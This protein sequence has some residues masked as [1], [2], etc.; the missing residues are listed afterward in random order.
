M[1]QKHTIKMKSSAAKVRGQGVASAYEEQVALV[2]NGLKDK[3]KVIENQWGRADI[4]HFHTVDF[5]FYLTIPYA[6][7]CGTAIGYVHFLPET[8]EQSLKLPRIAKKVFYRYLLR[9]Y[10]SM[11]MLVTV[12]PYFID[13]LEANG[14]P[15]EKVVYI[16]NFVSQK[17]FYPLSAEDKNALRLKY[18]IPAEKFV[19]VCAGQLQ[20]RKGIFD[21][22]EIAG[23]MPDVQF[24]W[25]GGFSFGKITDGY[26][27][28]RKVVENPPLNVLF[29]GIVDREQMNEIYNIG[30]VMFLPSYEEL[31]P[32]TVLEA[33]NCGL[34]L[35]LRDMPIY[36][37]I[38]FDYYMR[39]TDNEGFCRELDR[40]RQEAAYYEQAKQASWRGHLFYNEQHVAKMWDEFYSGLMEKEAAGKIKKRKKSKRA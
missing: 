26:E 15:R 20:T 40:L 33:M 25:A 5:W 18:K 23:R 19:V 9:F 27:K 6:K 16:P 38:L 39:A 11:D 29:T 13:R 34:P 24:V 10:K 28:I 21:F 8:M 14:V 12:N 4:T 1:K 36:E 22:L 3:F 31:F 17:E 35:L 37:N 7:L 2:K 32:M 30:D